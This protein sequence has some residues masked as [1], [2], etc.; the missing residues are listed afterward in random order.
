M[1][2]GTRV[3]ALRKEKGM[4]QSELANLLHTTQSAIGHWENNRRT[5]PQDKIIDIANIFNVTTDYLYG[6]ES[7]ET[8]DLKNIIRNQSIIYDGN[9][10][11][12]HDMQVIES[13]LDAV[14]NKE[15]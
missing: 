2:V 14:F 11:S 8:I 12:T 13:F 15:K 1:N 7:N 5:I 6:I 9:E 3:E 10:L 4:T